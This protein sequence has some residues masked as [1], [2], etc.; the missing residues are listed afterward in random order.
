MGSSWVAEVDISKLVA[1]D[2]GVFA[3]RPFAQVEEHARGKDDVEI[4]F[5]SSKQRRLETV[6]G[7]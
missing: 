6:R 5:E 4:D 1:K 7:G 2:C 3:L